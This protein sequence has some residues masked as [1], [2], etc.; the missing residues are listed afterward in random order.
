[1]V[2]RFVSIRFSRLRNTDPKGF[3]RKPDENWSERLCQ[4]AVSI[5]NETLRVFT[6]LSVDMVL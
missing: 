2:S 6:P 5:A 4:N 1:M 3:F